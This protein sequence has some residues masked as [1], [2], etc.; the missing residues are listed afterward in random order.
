M[1]RFAFNGLLSDG[2]AVYLDFAAV[3]IHNAYHGLDRR[4][5][6]RAVM[7]D[8]AV[9]VPVFHGKRQVVDRLCTAFCSFW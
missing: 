6:A 5:L 9:D 1:I 2:H 4:G 8:E 7:P 3:K